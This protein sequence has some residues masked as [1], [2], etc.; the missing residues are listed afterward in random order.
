MP[1]DSSKKNSQAT[2]ANAPGK[3]GAVV[4][5]VFGLLTFLVPQFLV[6]FVHASLK[7]GTTV[8][9]DADQLYMYA[10]SSLLTLLLISLLLQ[11]Y[12]TNL[13]GF[14]GKFKGNYLA[15]ALA[16]LPVYMVFSMFLHGLMT[17]VSSR[18]DPDQAQNVGFATGQD[19]FGLAMVFISLVV[20]PPIVEEVLFR[21]F[22]FK[23][24][25]KSFHPVLAAILTS[26]IFGLAHGQ[27]NVGIDTFALSLALCYLAYKTNSLWPSVLLHSLKNLIAFI[28]VFVITPEQLQLLWQQLM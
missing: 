24:F 18:Y 20:I 9:S 23:G 4:G 11:R 13:S 12:K 27:W 10:A 7:G 6:G 15:Y 19:G 25:Q 16:A 21:G 26:V 28:L 8:V 5:I 2:E 14:F 17:A 1:N 3:W 22:V